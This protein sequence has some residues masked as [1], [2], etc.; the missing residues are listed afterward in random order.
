MSKH[1]LYKPFARKLWLTVYR[2]HTGL[3]KLKILVK[4][5]KIDK[6]GPE[7]Q[8]AKYFRRQ[9][10]SGSCA[11]RNIQDFGGATCMLHGCV[12][13]LSAWTFGGR[14]WILDT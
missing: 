12:K 3:E 1:R 11:A 8:F 14:F 4:F 13:G 6:L 7:S 10:P 5:R 9:N 2:A